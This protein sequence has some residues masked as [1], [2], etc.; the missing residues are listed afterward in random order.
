M[1]LSKQTKRDSELV[2]YRNQLNVLMQTIENLEKI[3][4][5]EVIDDIRLDL[6]IL[7]YEEIQNKYRK[8]C[9]GVIKRKENGWI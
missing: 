5:R 1:K 2:N 7:K 4:K 6:S 3:K 8:M 9:M